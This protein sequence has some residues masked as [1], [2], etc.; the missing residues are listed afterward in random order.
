MAIS[1]YLLPGDWVRPEGIAV[2]PDRHFFAGSSADGTIYRCR[3]DEPTAQS[4]QPPRAD[5]RTAALG[6]AVYDSSQ[7]VVC[8]GETGHLFVYDL[9]TSELISRRTV[10]GFLNDVCVVGDEA[11]ATDSSQPIVW[12]LDLS[13]DAAPIAI[14]LPD[15]GP[16][17]Y[18][19]G[20]VTAP[21]D[22]ALLVAAQGTE[23]LWRLDLTDGSAQAIAHDFAADGLL[24]LGDV[25]VGVCNEGDS[26][27]TAEFFLAAL[28][29][30]DDARTAVPL[31]RFTDPRF[32][33]PTT[34]DTD[35]E[36][37]LVVNA[38]F[39]RGSAAGPPF[40]V[41]AVPLPAFS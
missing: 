20:I 18:L 4:W 1:E 26:M 27:D 31:G 3:L 9:A 39:A 32:D 17:A 13:S 33:T 22:T 25:L 41:I 28:K 38:Q 19:N 29:L 16:D 12:R 40:Q 10:E 7:L 14:D 34:L 37:L 30:A 15:A 24:V 23:V 35:G 6:L 5:G 8:G 21:C 2:G 11:Y 36:R